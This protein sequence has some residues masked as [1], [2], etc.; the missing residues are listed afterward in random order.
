[1]KNLVATVSAAAMPALTACS[2]NLYAD[3]TRFYANQPITRGP[4]AV[5]PIDPAL[6]NSLKFRTHAEIL[7]D[8]LSREFPGAT[9]TAIRV[10]I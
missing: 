8:A 6:A 1:M 3:V 7:A 10:R 2:N 4:L 9:G 5:V